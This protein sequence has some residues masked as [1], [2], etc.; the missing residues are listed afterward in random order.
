M[1]ILRKYCMGY[2]PVRIQVLSDQTGHF[3]S[4]ALTGGGRGSRTFN[5]VNYEDPHYNVDLPV[6]SIH[7]NHDDP[8]REGDQL[9]SALDLLSMANL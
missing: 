4:S 7:G 6:F 9:L 5:R 3:G 1:E 8:S 2:N